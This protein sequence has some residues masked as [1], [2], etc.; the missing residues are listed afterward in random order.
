MFTQA[1]KLA[2]VNA[3]EDRIKVIGRAQK[4]GRFPAM[5]PFFEKEVS[6]LRV[7][8]EKVKNAKGS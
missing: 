2:I 6:D 5:A 8:I 1:E 3:L 7:L 4:V